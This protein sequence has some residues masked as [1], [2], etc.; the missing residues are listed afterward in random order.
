MSLTAL[1][2]QR[3]KPGRHSDG[4]GLYLLVKPSGA[5]SWVLRVQYRGQRRDFGLGSVQIAA[6]DEAGAAR[7]P[8]LDRKALT[9]MEAR[10]KA[11]LGRQLAKAGIN[12]SLE[13]KREDAVVPTFEEAARLYHKAVEQTWRNGKHGGQWISTLETYAFPSLGALPVNEIDAPAIRD[14][15]LPFWLTKGETARRVRQRIAVVL[16]YS[17]GQGWRDTEAPMRALNSL[18]KG[19][20]QPKGGNFKA[21]PHADLPAFMARLRDEAASVGR[22][23]LQFTILTAARSGEVRGATWREVDLEAAEWKIPQERMKAGKLHIVPLVPAALDILR[24]MQ[25]LFG[26]DPDAPIFPGMK[27]K[28]MSDATLAK[29]LRVT[30]GGDNTVHGFRSTFRDWAADTGFADAWA[31]ASLAHGNPD[32]IEAA[33][34]RT[35]FLAHRREKLMPAWAR[36]ALGDGSNVIR[37]TATK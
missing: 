1:Q 35:S 9:L 25:G 28:A 30:G 6:R 16:D 8:L 18:L 37:L 10:E 14:V 33:Y 27:G 21:M 31:E 12:P 20:R 2:V 24:E 29:A 3:A 13:W 11:A 36:F 5:R 4:K 15:L 23:A 19:L 17:K 26:G 22:L 32:R 7:I 34:R